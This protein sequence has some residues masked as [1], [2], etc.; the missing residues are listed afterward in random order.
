MGGTGVRSSCAAEPL[1]SATLC[2]L[3]GRMLDACPFLGRL[4]RS[5]TCRLCLPYEDNLWG[6]GRCATHTVCGV[7]VVSRP[8]AG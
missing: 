6:R 7:G 8:L 5:C 2:R 4:A 1:R 3:P